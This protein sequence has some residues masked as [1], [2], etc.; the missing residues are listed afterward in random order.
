MK[1]PKPAENSFE[2][3]LYECRLNEGDEEEGIGRDGSGPIG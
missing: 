1:P 2:V 3:F